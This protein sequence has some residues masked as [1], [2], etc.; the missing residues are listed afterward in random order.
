[1][2]KLIAVLATALIL[3]LISSGQAQAQVVCSYGCGY[4][5]VEKWKT[6]A[7]PPEGSSFEN[8]DCSVSVYCDGCQLTGPMGLR[9]SSP[10]A[11]LAAINSASP[12]DLG[13]VINK[14]RSRLLLHG[15]R[16]LVVVRG[17]GCDPERL[18]S[19]LF[20]SSQKM[21]TLS[22]LGIQSL[23]HFVNQR[24]QLAALKKTSSASKRV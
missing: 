1:M 19:V 7:A 12:K 18:G 10:E 23:E 2:R 21:A 3:C 20:L 6:Q 16:N 13:S 15:P 11:I 17:S 22:R 8:Q 14:Y 24:T 9:A 5:G 4:C